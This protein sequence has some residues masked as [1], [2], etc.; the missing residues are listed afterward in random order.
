MDRPMRHRRCLRTVATVPPKK[1][2]SANNPPPRRRRHLG[3]DTRAAPSPIKVAPHPLRF[4][5][6]VQ[7]RKHFSSADAEGSKLRRQRAVA[8]GDAPLI[9]LVARL[10][11]RPRNI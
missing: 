8:C 2:L 11:A 3:S 1:Q 4:Y 7:P 10:A 6:R 9:P 5:Q